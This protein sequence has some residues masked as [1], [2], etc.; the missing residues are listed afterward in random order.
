MLAG[1]AR[2]AKVAV[3]DQLTL[4]IGM[5]VDGSFQRQPSFEVLSSDPDSAVPA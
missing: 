5:G 1:F 3:A 4:F 2:P